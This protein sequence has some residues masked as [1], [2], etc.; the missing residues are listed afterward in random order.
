MAVRN[1]TQLLNAYNA[2]MGVAAEDLRRHLNA[3][4]QKVNV[5]I[6]TVAEMIDEDPRILVAIS[7]GRQV[8]IPLSLFAKLLIATG[9]SIAIVPAEAMP[10]Q[11]QAPMNPMSVRGG[12]PT[13][14]Q[15][16]C[17]GT[18]LDD[19][20]AGQCQRTGLDHGF[21]GG[22][23]ARR[24]RPMRPNMPPIG[25][26][27]M[28]GF[29]GMPQGMPYPMPNPNGVLPSPEELQAME[30]ARMDAERDRQMM[31]GGFPNIP[32]GIPMPDPEDFDDELDS[33]DFADEA[34]DMNPYN[35]TMETPNFV[36]E[37]RVR[38]DLRGCDT[39]QLAEALRNNPEVADLLR[40]ILR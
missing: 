38:E 28:G 35:T 36:P 2:W 29:A 26:T 31:G 34:P 19:G 22:R 15:N 33:E 7:E 13:I 8:N 25:M 18:G 5:P 23:P 16:Q 27:P 14:P 20:I 12:Q 21:G 30:Q 4:A 10:Q 24:P 3:F 37:E 9:H 17:Q 40:R 39:A 11:A 32:A 6:E 1:K